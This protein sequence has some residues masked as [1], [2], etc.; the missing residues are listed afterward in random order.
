ML[1]FLPRYILLLFI[2]D[3]C[4]MSLWYEQNLNKHECYQ[5][6]INVTEKHHFSDVDSRYSIHR[7]ILIL[8]LFWR[9]YEFKTMYLRCVFNLAKVERFSSVLLSTF[10]ILPACL[11]SSCRLAFLWQK[12]TRLITW[13]QQY[14]WDTLRFHIFGV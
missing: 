7:A 13:E 6:D 12:I 2:T 1:F 14:L 8:N 3:K 9:I 10:K 11:S 5:G 4:R